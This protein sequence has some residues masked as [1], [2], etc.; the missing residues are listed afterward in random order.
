VKFDKYKMNGLTMTT[1]IVVADYQNEQH[2]LDLVQM[3]DCYATDPMGGGE[4]LSTSSKAN[5]VQE[6]S[7]R[8]FVFSLLAYVD[9]KP[10]GLAN[11]IESFS[12]FSC[13]PV[14]NIH[15]LAV[16][17]EHRGLGI[18]QLLLTKIEAIAKQKGASKITLEVLSGNDVAINA[19][20]K[21]GFSGYELDPKMGKAEFWEKKI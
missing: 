15:D 3:L 21:F 12:T 6:L 13:K 14:I 16:S 5:L 1:D 11:C 10:A 20:K 19:Y 18:S 17:P 9:G 4:P 7:K 8:N 2:A